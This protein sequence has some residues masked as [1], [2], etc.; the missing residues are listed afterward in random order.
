MVKKKPRLKPLI[1]PVTP[2]DQGPA[3]ERGS[4]GPAGPKGSPG[5]A[6]RPGEAGLPGAKVNP[7]PLCPACPETLALCGGWNEAPGAG[8]RICPLKGPLASSVTLTHM[9]LSPLH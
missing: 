3:G 4:P 1:V 8:P 5:E 2:P 6:G 9:S 7:P